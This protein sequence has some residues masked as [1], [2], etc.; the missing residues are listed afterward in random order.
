MF[1]QGVCSLFVNPVYE[2]VGSPT[3]YIFWFA[4]YTYILIKK[5]KKASSDSAYNGATHVVQFAVVRLQW[6]FSLLPSKFRVV[7]LFI[8]SFNCG[9]PL[10]IGLYL[11]CLFFWIFFLS[12]LS[13]SIWFYLI[14]YIKYGIHSFDCCFSILFLICFFFNFIPQRFISF[15][16][17]IQFLS[18]FF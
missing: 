10:L 16:Y 4:I 14:F 18:S 15:I 7:L 17:F 3:L 8:F 2:P 12:I 5:K 13:L 6:D 9:P 1:F 11:F